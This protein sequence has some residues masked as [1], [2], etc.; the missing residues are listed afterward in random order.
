MLS[1][2][3]T[4]I[5]PNEF[6]SCYQSYF[7]HFDCFDCEGLLPYPGY[8]ASQASVVSNLLPDFTNGVTKNFYAFAQGS[9]WDIADYT[10]QVTLT[11]DDVA[12]TLGN[13]WDWMDHIQAIANEFRFVFL[14]ACSTASSPWHKAFGIFPTTYSNEASRY[15]VGPQAF[16]GWNGT[17]ELYGGETNLGAAAHM[18]LALAHAQT[19]DDFYFDWMSGAP[20]AQCIANASAM[21]PNVAPFPVPENKRVLIC[22]YELDDNYYCYSSTN[23]ITSQILVAGHSGLMVSGL[24]GGFDGYFVSGIYEHR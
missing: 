20:L 12:A 22:G 7:D 3:D 9:L 4:V 8:V 24:D 10:G 15:M 18:N 23:L 5:M 21:A 11:A 6:Y 17:V 16:V 2:V 1:V 14:D 13:D 19:L